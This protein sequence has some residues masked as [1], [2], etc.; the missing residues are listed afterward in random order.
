VYRNHD[1][2]LSISPSWLS[3]TVDTASIAWGDVDDDG[4]PDLAVGVD[5]LHNLLLRN[6]T[7][8]GSASSILDFTLDWSS[9]NAVR[10]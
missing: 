1:G 3:S 4:D 10:I 7:V 9:T 6:D 8:Q 2:V 5:G